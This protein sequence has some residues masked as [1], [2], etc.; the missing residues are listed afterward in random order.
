MGY[1]TTANPHQP[2]TNL[3]HPSLPYTLTDA[4]SFLC[5]CMPDNVSLYSWNNVFDEV[6][7]YRP[8]NH[9]GGS[10]A[11]DSGYLSIST[12]PSRA[13][14]YASIPSEVA[15]FKQLTDMAL[16]L[17]VMRI[18]LD[19]LVKQKTLVDRCLQQEQQEFA[20][21]HRIKMEDIKVRAGWQQL[22]IAALMLW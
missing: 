7:K 19:G 3:P 4:T 9:Y 5:S 12:A 17:I 15:V 18:T 8:D 14:S 16:E 13:T 21:T 10:V 2:P 1:S 20:V 11:G 22:P 6:D